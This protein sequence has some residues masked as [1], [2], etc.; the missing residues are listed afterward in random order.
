MT[1]PVQHRVKQ[2]RRD[3]RQA[4]LGEWQQ[5]VGP[6]EHGGWPYAFHPVVRMPRDVVCAIAD[7][8]C[9]RWDGGPWGPVADSLDISDEWW[10][11]YTSS[12]DQPARHPDASDVE[13]VPARWAVTS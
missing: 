7:L 5:Y 8:A 11:Y 6:C 13:W 3:M 4:G 1:G 12:P 2:L 10:A 9:A